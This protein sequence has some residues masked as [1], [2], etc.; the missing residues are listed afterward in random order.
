[1]KNIITIKIY[2]LDEQTVDHITYIDNIE[3]KEIEIIDDDLLYYFEK[4]WV[5]DLSLIHQKHHEDFS[6]DGKY[7]ICN[8][9]NQSTEIG[10]IQ[11]EYELDQ[12]CNSFYEI[13]KNCG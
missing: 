7:L 4:Y 10:D 8:S 13:H 2:L 12:L 5:E 9:C 6:I 11:D 1:M 3:N